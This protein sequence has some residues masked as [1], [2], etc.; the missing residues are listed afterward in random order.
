MKLVILRIEK[1]KVICGIN[2]KTKI[3]VSIARRW[4]AE[5]IQE[6]D[7]IDLDMKIYNKS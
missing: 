2:S 7:T 5:D 1:R 3:I 4:F 6:G